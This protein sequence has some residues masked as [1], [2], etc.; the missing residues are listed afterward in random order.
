MFL[1][2]FPHPPTHCTKN[3][4]YVFQE[5]ILS[6]FVPNSHIHISVSNLYI[7]RIGLYFAAAK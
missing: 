2:F 7:P 5:M 1:V 4:I 6:G 3:P